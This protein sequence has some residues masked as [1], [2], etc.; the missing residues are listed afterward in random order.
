MMGI[1]QGGQRGL[2]AATLLWVNASKL[3]TPAVSRLKGG[4]EGVSENEF[5]DW[6]GVKTRGRVRLLR[7][8]NRPIS[9]TNEHCSIPALI[10]DGTLTGTELGIQRAPGNTIGDGLGQ[11]FS[12]FNIYGYNNLGT[13]CC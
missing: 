13:P 6:L 10:A 3:E 2:V 12:F 5:P 8:C 1:W 11:G 7:T 9:M 4:P